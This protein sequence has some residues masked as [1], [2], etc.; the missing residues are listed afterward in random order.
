[1]KIGNKGFLQLVVAVFFGAAIPNSV[2]AD[3]ILFDPDGSGGSSAFD[4]NYFQFGAGNSLAQGAVPFTVGNI[5][6]LLFHAQLNSVVTTTGAQ[7]TPLGLN[8]SYEVTLVGSVTERVVA[9]NAGPPE[10]VTFQLANNQAAESFV[11]LYYDPTPDADPLQGAGY[12]DGVLILQGRVPAISPDVGTF[13][14]TDPQPSRLPNF[15]L[16]GNNDYLTA[17]TGGVNITSV[18]G[19]GSTRL[20][21]VI[22]YINPDFFPATEGSATAVKQNDTLILEISQATPFDGVNPSR[23]FTAFHNTSTDATPTPSPT[24]TPGPSATPRVGSINGTNGPDFQA[25]SLIG[26]S[27]TAGTPTPTPGPS[28]TPTPT[29]SVTPT[30]TP[31]ATPTATP[32]PTGPKVIVQASRTQL[33][34]GSDS[35]ITFSTNQSVHPD[36]PIFYSVS[37]T[38]TL[39]VDYT[40]SQTSGQVVIPANQS[41]ASI[42]LHSIPDSV[43]EPNGEAAKILLQ[44]HSG[45]QVPANNDANRVVILIL[46]R[47]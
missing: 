24:A 12:S 4:I 34:E 44:P 22:D 45:Y 42:L 28:I 47:I 41:S 2:R 10:R 33:R 21:I 32:V 15:D 20:N 26:A 31:T 13:A 3:T 19:T 46:D 1:M 14:L 43:S 30:V 5:F 27:I 11:E 38:A 9:V 8:S 16:F 29:P 35:T 37:G 23:T 6:Q 17:G 7:M 36:I 40:L 25:E 39:N 18:V